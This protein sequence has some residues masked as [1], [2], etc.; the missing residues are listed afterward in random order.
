MTNGF[1][2]CGA[3]GKWYPAKILNLAKTRRTE[4]A[5]RYEGALEGKDVI[6]SADEVAA[7]KAIRYLHAR[8]WFGSL[9]NEMGLP[10]GAFHASVVLE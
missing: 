8:P 6:I 4:G 5:L 9:Y 1:E 3:D 7:P 2:I 10:L